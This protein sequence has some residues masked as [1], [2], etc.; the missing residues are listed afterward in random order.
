[1]KVLLLV[2][3]GLERGDVESLLVDFKGTLWVRVLLFLDVVCV[4]WVILE[5]IECFVAV[6]LHLA[7]EEFHLLIT[8]S[9]E[10]LW[11][12]IVVLDVVLSGL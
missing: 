2:S 5:I 3:L 7:R 10:T 11:I 12:C 6:A 9:I 4:R 1:M 8:C